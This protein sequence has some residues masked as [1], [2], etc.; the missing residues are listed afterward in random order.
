MRQRCYYNK[1]NNFPNYG[2]RGIRIC[3]A[4]VSKY[5]VFRDWAL[6]NGYGE[7]LTIERLDVNKDYS[8][9]NCTWIPMSEQSV[10]KRINS[11]NSTGAT[12]IHRR[13]NGRYYCIINFPNRKALTI[14]N[15][16]SLLEAAMMREYMIW[17]EDLYIKSM[18]V[19]IEHVK[20]AF[21][22]DVEYDV[23]VVK[24]YIMGVSLTEARSITQGRRNSGYI[25]VSKNAKG[26]SNAW[27]RVN[28]KTVSIP[29]GVTSEELCARY[30]NTYVIVNDLDKPLNT[31]VGTV[32]T[33]AL[34]EI[35]DFSKYNLS[36]LLELNNMIEEE[37]VVNANNK[38]GFIGIS[39]GK[40][41]GTFTSEIKS[42]GL[43]NNTKMSLG[44]YD[45]AEK[46][47]RVREA[48]I[49]KYGL[50]IRRNG[51]EVSELAG[52][53]VDDVYENKV[54]AMEYLK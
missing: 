18:N 40:K 42:K 11:N 25:G 22:K 50:T 17:R 53:L 13:D 49:V 34:A 47:A 24:A 45:T 48:Y 16:H 6:A 32:F 27:V 30:Y 33:K 14:T 4:W 5:S 41:K 31:G 26:Y 1:S 44:V 43:N 21:P 46:A 38:M 36:Q 15:M 20:K 10:N 28:G 3:D 9:K 35:V 23:E 39:K 29:G 2:A 54:I 7:G 12:G 52:M 37:V 8:P 19:D 51:L